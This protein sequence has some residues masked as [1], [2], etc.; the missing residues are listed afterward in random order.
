MKSVLYVIQ[1]K[2]I[3]KM[4]MKQGSFKPDDESDLIKVTKKFRY[5]CKAR[6]IPRPTIGKSNTRER[7]LG[8][9]INLRT[10][11]VRAEI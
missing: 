4:E 2:R 3:E 6:R 7:Y 1:R 5:R 10:K 11:C 8:H 9:L